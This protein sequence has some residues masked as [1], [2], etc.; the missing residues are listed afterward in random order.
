[1]TINV[2]AAR[3]ALPS[4]FSRRHLAGV[5][6]FLALAARTA[7]AA[8]IEPNAA[9]SAPANAAPG[10]AVVVRPVV[11]MF[12]R[13]SLEVDVVSQAICST[14][15]A[16]LRTSDRWTQIR[17]P[18]DYTGWV[19]SAA[20]RALS[21]DE[22][23]PAASASNSPAAPSSNS[24]A[25]ASDPS[26][27]GASGHGS[28]NASSDAS[29]DAS[30]NASP[31]ATVAQVENLAAHVYREPDVTKHA[32][33]HTLPFDVRLQVLEEDP[34]NERWIE[35]R[36]PDQHKAWIQRGDVSLAPSG[37]PRVWTIPELIAL[38]QRFLGRPYTWGGTSSFGYDCSGF[39][40]MLCR[41][42][43]VLIP[44]DA[45]VQAAW[46][47]MTKLERTSLEAGD[48]LFFGEK[49]S[50][51]THTGFYLGDGR[52]IHSTVHGTPVIQISRLDDA[53]WTTLL[54]VCR[55]WKR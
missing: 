44:R 16:T 48:L 36:L 40:Q 8:T 12:S 14:T 18:D 33:L 27:T 7:L 34:K 53:P 38:S 51:I 20:L 24:S 25:D 2:F 1:M 19:V 11:N 3:G 17:T 49:A 10:R 39:T 42:G 32:P 28:S 29:S 4:R 23:Y 52:F 41:R 45:D 50:H 15:V 37:T 30:S 26:S 35:V 13:S 54:V 21:P 47:G 31:H 55:R 22:Q 5:V 43:G 9:S 6:P 46:S